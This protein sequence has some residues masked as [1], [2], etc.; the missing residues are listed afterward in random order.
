MTSDILFENLF[1]FCGETLRLRPYGAAV[2]GRP[3]KSKSLTKSGGYA[4]RPLPRVG[5]DVIQHVIQQVW[6]V[7]YVNG[8]VKGMS[9]GV[10]GGCPGMSGDVWGVTGGCPG[11]SQGMSGCPGF[12]RGCP[13]CHRGMSG[14]SGDV[15][16]CRRMSE[17]V[18][19]SGD[20]I[21]SLEPPGHPLTSPDILRHPPTSPDIPG[22]P[23][24]SPNILCDVPDILCD[25]QANPV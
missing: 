24:T 3:T 13:G 2:S 16:G 5:G 23:R 9:G 6:D 22:H 11:G 15:K 20:V 1:S 18:G 14:M 7:R 21:L 25:I 12:H 8:D 17:D 19:M 10:T 4:P